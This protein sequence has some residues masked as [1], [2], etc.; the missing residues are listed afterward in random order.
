MENL[1]KL[2]NELIKLPNETEWLEFKHNNA[3]PEMIG[4]DISALANSATLSDRSRAYMIWGIDDTTH[5][6]VGTDVRLKQQKIGNQELEN[7]LRSLLSKHADFSFESIDFP[8]NKHVEILVIEKAL[9][10][11][12]VFEKIA[13]IRVGSYTKKLQEYDALQANLWDKLR[14]T[15][16]ENIFAKTDLQAHEAL[17]LLNCE[18]YFDTLQIPIPQEREKYIHYLQEEGILHPQDDGLYAITNLGALLFA[19]RLADF[20]RVGRKAIRVVQYEGENKYAIKKEEVFDEGYA[21]SFEK[22]I[23]FITA[24]L[25]ST[26]D[27]NAILRTTKLPFPLPAIRE[28]IANSLVHQDLFVTGAGPLV[29]IFSNRIEITNPGVPL[30]NIIRIVDNPPK[31]RNEKLASLMRRLNMCEEL[32]RGW[33]RMVISCEIEQIPAPHIFVYQESTKVVLFSHL[34]FI[35]IPQEEKQWSTYLHACVKYLEGDALTNTSLRN[36]FGVPNTSSSS[37][38]RLIKEVASS[39]LELIR[40][41]DP[42][43]APRYMRYI[44]IWG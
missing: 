6:I 4:K 32:G 25:P 21:M 16:F 24:I 27:T 29:E 11:P 34:D 13:Y 5:E 19:K 18:S 40:P 43:T 35:N 42:H 9:A 38:S 44:P 31:S 10:I 30:V 3:K 20:P 15:Q 1:D 8:N 33:D 22:S 39:P 7:W 28:A 37:I 14:Q 12:I 23:R 17:S 2:V 36:R 41:I 26:E